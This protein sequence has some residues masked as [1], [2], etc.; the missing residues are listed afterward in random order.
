MLVTV[1]A[2]AMPLGAAAQPAAAPS[3][4][5]VSPS[6]TPMEDGPVLALTLDDALRLAI[7]N[8]PN[9]QSVQELQRQAGARIGEARAAAGPT[10][11]AAA[12][13][14]RQGPIPTFEFSA[15]P[16][17]PARRVRLGAPQSGTAELDATYRPDLSG[18][19]SASVRIARAGA[20]A[21]QAV[22]A[23]T[24]NDLTYQVQN[25]YYGA[26]RTRELVEVRRQA[27]S[28]AQEQLRVAQA[29]FRAG[30]VP[31]FDVLRASVQVENL[32]QNQTVAERDARVAVATLVDVMGVDPATRLQLAPVPVT[33]LPPAAGAPGGSPAAPP[34]SSPATG[35]PSAPVRDTVIPPPPGAAAAAEMVRSTGGKGRAARASL[36]SRATGP[37][38]T[39]VAEAFAEAVRLRPE[40]QEAR[41]N[42]Q[43]NEARVTFERRARRP[44]LA[45]TG[46]YT[47]TPQAS[48]LASVDKSWRLGVGLTLNL[49]DA[50][51]IRSRVREAEAGRDSSAAILERTRQ[52]VA[53]QVRTA[54]LNLQEAQDR[55]QT[56]A[57]NVQQAQEAL[58]ISQVRYRAGVATNVEVTD[59]QVALTEAQTNQVNAEYD[60]LNAQA[61]LARALGRYAPPTAGSATP[62]IPRK[63]FPRR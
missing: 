62:S 7:A 61:A 33:P 42:V 34:P 18:R 12:N 57:A 41:E 53:L 15:Q 25:D 36:G 21:A 63:Q 8:N 28:A 37:L 9:L 54:L 2:V 39:A 30:T 58:R 32:R 11:N 29:Q 35:R 1:T 26:L 50:G 60:F 5:P 43:Q 46:A 14:L 13:Y 59:A 6:A 55:R 38:P 31:Q 4:A 49:F 17:Q 19:T 45:L 3:A 24:V 44:D 27:V 47:Y 16:G 51:L 52:Q 22:T 20:E 48:G 10:L 23:T 56:T 40:V